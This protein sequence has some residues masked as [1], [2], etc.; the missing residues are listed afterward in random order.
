MPIFESLDLWQDPQPRSGAVNMAVD[1]LLMERV[2]AVGGRPLLRIYEWCEPTVTFGYSLP[3]ADAVEA[4]PEGDGENY[5]TYVRRWTGGGVVDHR[6]DL[7]YTL[8]VPRSHALATARGAES[9]RVIHQ[10]LADTLVAMGE[11]VRLTVVDEGDGGSACF[12]NPVAYDL[13]NGS[14]AKIAGAG[15][16]RTRYGL[17]HQG[18]VI[19]DGDVE[20]FGRELGKHFSHH[21]TEYS[22]DVDFLEAATT[23]ARD[24]YA[25]EAWL[26]RVS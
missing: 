19:T 5:L 26:E 15:Q 16:R 8:V 25:T 4:F 17:L 18:S 7:T 6:I 9:Y 10:V 3:L 21:V 22:P 11:S 14:G 1:Q 20:A 2:G 23:L 12:T 13:T 24:R